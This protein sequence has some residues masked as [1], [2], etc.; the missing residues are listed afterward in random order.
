MHIHPRLK[1][2]EDGVYVDPKPA[3]AISAA[4]KEYYE[5][6]VDKWLS[7]DRN[8]YTRF[9]RE[10]V[11]REI[12]QEF[13]SVADI[14]G[15]HPKLASLLNVC[16]EITVFD[17]YPDIYEKSHDKFTAL[18]PVKCPVKYEKK[19]ITHPKFSPN[20]ELAI[21]CHVLEHLKLKQIKRLFENI[22]CEKI[23]VYGPDM[24]QARSNSWLHYRPLD[25]RT[26]ITRQKMVELIEAAGFEVRVSRNFS[27]D[28]VIFG[29]KSNG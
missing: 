8:H 25:H 27:Q 29:V 3:K 6:I 20:A 22:E 5:E 24:S 28:Y 26:F 18:Y 13:Y 2:V 9:K 11:D 10:V 4:M 23:L 17:Q 16:G 1:K 21:F 14:G 7:D 15:G 19:N 12:N